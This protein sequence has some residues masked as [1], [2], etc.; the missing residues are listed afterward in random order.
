MT[1][2]VTRAR[3]RLAESRGQHQPPRNRDMFSYCEARVVHVLRSEERTD[4]AGGD[5]IE[6][7]SPTQ[8]MDTVSSMARFFLP[9]SY[10]QPYPPVSACLHDA[11]VTV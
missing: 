6:H 8:D 4:I 11:K 1:G 5:V 3:T 7:V 9:T 2:V 10:Y